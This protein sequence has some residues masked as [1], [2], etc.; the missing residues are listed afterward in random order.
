MRTR[1]C[2]RMFFGLGFIRADFVTDQSVSFS[3]R[4]VYREPFAR[5]LSLTA[6]D[7]PQPQQVPPYGVDGLANSGPALQ[8]LAV[9]VGS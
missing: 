3:C 7:F 9:G 8:S 4:S 2:T 1:A 5:A 6:T